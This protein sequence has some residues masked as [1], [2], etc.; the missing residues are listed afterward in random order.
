MQRNFSWYVS[1][2]Y[3]QGQRFCDRN[4]MEYGIGS[5]QNYFLVCIH[6]HAGISMYELAKMGHFDKGTVTKGIQKLEEQGYIRLEA[7]GSDRRIKRLYTTD[8]AVPIIEKLYEMSQEW[9]D[10]LADGMTDEERAQVRSL[11]GRM[12]EN[13]WKYMNEKELK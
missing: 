6:E 10:I 11:M 1:M 5:G 3:R 2:M 12:A 9:N 13:A 4:L 7:D 8:Q